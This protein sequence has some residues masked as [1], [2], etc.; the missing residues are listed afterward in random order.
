M[1]A[2]YNW[3][4]KWSHNVHESITSKGW[5]TCSQ[6][7]FNHGRVLAWIL[8]RTQLIVSEY[9]INSSQLNAMSPFPCK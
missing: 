3:D 7:L 5:W 6:L 2:I 1:L 9:E 8:C 4:L